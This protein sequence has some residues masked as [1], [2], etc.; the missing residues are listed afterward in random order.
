MVER[1][2]NISFDER[3]WMKIKQ[4]EENA[5][6]YS[7]KSSLTERTKSIKKKPLNIFFTIEKNMKM[8]FNPSTK[9]SDLISLIKKESK[10][11]ENRLNKIIGISSLNNCEV[12]DYWLTLPNKTINDIRNH[13]SLHVIYNFTYVDYFNEKAQLNDF[14]FIKC[15]GKGGAADVYLGFFY[16]FIIYLLAIFIFFE[17]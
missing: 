11:N 9:C 15:I 1:K 2:S 13:E 6:I 5:T 17:K 12:L 14:E 16:F 7:K 3:T 10:I 8:F 4:E